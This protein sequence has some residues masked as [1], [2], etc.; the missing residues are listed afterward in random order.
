MLSPPRAANI[1]E[2]EKIVTEWKHQQMIISQEDKL[3]MDDDMRMTLMLG[4]MP[5]EFVKGMRTN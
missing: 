3:T 4:M 1:K 2:M 5:K